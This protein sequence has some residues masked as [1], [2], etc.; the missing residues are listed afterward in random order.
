MP[1][2]FANRMHCRNAYRHKSQTIRS[3]SHADAALTNIAISTYNHFV[4]SL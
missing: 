4:S 3:I 1:F 2:D